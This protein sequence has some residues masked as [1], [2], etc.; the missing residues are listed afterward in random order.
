MDEMVLEG[1]TGLTE[2]RMLM[3]RVVALIIYGNNEV[4]ETL[5]K[6]T[7]RKKKE[8]RMDVDSEGGGKHG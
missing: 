4:G 1:L 5:K 3:V 2:T 8:G 6:K 7:V